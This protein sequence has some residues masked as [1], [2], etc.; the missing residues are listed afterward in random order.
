MP[1]LPEHKEILLT[2]SESKTLPEWVDYF[3]GQYDKKT[4]SNFIYHNKRK[5]KKLDKTTKSMIQ[6]QNARK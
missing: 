4:I 5:P 2:Q 1:I 6:S 3:G